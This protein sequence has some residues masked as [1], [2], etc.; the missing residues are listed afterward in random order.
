MLPNKGPVS[1]PNTNNPAAQ[2]GPEAASAPPIKQLID[3]E[4]LSLLMQATA[5]LAGNLDERLQ[6]G[7][8]GGFYLDGGRI[9]N[10]N[11]K[12]QMEEVCALKKK[13]ENLEPI[14]KKAIVMAEPEPVQEVATSKRA[15]RGKG[16]KLEAAIAP[17]INELIQDM[18]DM[19]SKIKSQEAQIK[20]LQD[21]NKSLGT[22]VAQLQTKADKKASGFQLTQAKWQALDNNAKVQEEHAKRIDQL[23]DRISGLTHAQTELLNNKNKVQGEHSKQI[24]QL[25]ERVMSLETSPP[26]SF[27]AQIVDVRKHIDRLSAASATLRSNSGNFEE[28]ISTALP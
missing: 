12:Q 5:K 14:M 18:A 15:A 22:A 10:S 23:V 24:D 4:A 20:H 17:M 28:D 16:G 11:L 1:D 25:E 7:A 21:E 8:K 26:A 2:Q 9:S 3:F 6:G 13:I 27:S 19:R